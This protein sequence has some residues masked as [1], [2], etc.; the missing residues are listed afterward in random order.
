M[1]SIK[2]L[3]PLNAL[4]L[5]TDPSNPRLGDFYLNSTTNLVRVYSSTG[6]I[7]L[8]AGAGGGAAVHIGTTPPETF[9]EGDLWFDNVNV[10]F[11]TYDGTYWVEVSF[12]PVGPSGPG[13]PTG[14]TV[15]QV[16]A[17]ASANDYDTTWVTPYTTNSFASDFLARTTDS[18]TEG[19]TR[20]Y[21]T[22][23]RAI[24][25]TATAVAG[26]VTTANAYTDTQISNVIDSA[27]GA[28]NTLNEI[29]AAIG[30]NADFATSVYN[31]INVVKAS[32]LDAEIGIIMGA[33]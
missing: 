16:P 28:L 27:P 6:W 26:A 17:K 15:G 5:A 31:E 11:Y 10:H 19:T 30:D 21:F 12:G 2:R 33:L 18:L 1:S 7:D 8:G 25:A 29:A 23:Q 3:V 22:A 9:N 14:G 4:S 24:D 32:V 13:L 20:L